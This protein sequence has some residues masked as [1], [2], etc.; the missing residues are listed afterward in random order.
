MGH[1]DI[2][3]EDKSKGTVEHN[4]EE[5]IGNIHVTKEKENTANT[6]SAEETAD[7]TTA[8]GQIS[9]EAENNVL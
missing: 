7:Q 5:T 2:T 3:Q 1:A 8:S 6:T 9:S 4:S